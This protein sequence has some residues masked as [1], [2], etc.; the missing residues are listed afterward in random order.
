MQWFW[1]WLAERA[2][3]RSKRLAIVAERDLD[4]AGWWS[5]VQA[6]A[7]SIAPWADLRRRRQR[8]SETGKG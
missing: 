5:D 4:R 1:N 3:R 6:W 7:D 8:N 2:H